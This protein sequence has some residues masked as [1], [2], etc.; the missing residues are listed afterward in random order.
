MTFPFIE[1]KDTH[2]IKLLLQPATKVSF[3]QL[4]NK[5]E[6]CNG[7]SH[8][9]FRTINYTFKCQIDSSAYVCNFL[10]FMWNCYYE[11]GA[12]LFCF[13]SSVFMVPVFSFSSLPHNSVSPF[14]LSSLLFSPSPFLSVPLHHTHN[15]IVCFTACQEILFSSIN[16]PQNSF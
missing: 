2:I 3:F 7:H 15:L 5:T 16:F 4:P 13:L 10:S 11:L 1:S 8:S 6:N 9:W 12:E 14:P